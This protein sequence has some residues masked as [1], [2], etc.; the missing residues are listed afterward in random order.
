[1]GVGIYIDCL[2]VLKNLGGDCRPCLPSP[3][4]YDTYAY[5]GIFVPMHT[6]LPTNI[7]TPYA[8]E[9]MKQPAGD[10]IVLYLHLYKKF[11]KV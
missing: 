10:C 2:P 9:N 7:H 11:S 8:H 3:A 4:A 6:H 5:A 1:M